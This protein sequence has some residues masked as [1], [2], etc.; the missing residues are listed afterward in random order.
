[1]FK[2]IK[3]VIRFI[4]SIIDKKF[5]N[6]N[7]GKSIY[8][9]LFDQFYQKLIIKRAEIE[10][11]GTKKIFNEYIEN[12]YFKIP[13]NFE[14][15]VT[16]LKKNLMI[17]DEKTVS[18]FCIIYKIDKNVKNL[19]YKFINNEI[20]EYLDEISKFY[21]SNVYLANIK[22]SKNLNIT[23]GK[24]YYAN[25]YHIDNNRFTLFKLFIPLVDVS[26]ND[27]PTH[28]IPFKYK[29]KFVSDS[30]YLSRNQELKEVNN[31]I[32]YKN[33]AKA[34]EILV[35]NTARCFHRAGVPE[36]NRSRLLLNLSFVAYPKEYEN[37][38]FFDF[39]EDKQLSKDLNFNFINY[40]TKSKSRFDMINLFY[41]Y[42]KFSKF[43]FNN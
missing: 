32:V 12:G 41:Q 37:F 36:K 38:K 17:D 19:V 8:Y 16:E 21:R 25:N 31:S 18:K 10:K 28:I 2:F 11:N 9:S 1:M 33:V 4:L 15:F 42:K 24:E 20:N 3:K 27:G 39:F 29:K 14:K 7:G 6:K 23:D 40:F 43:N 5:S 13:K 34:G 35:C 30:G 26:I 22:I